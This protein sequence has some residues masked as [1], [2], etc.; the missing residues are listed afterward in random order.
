VKDLCNSSSLFF[1]MD[2]LIIQQ[3]IPPYVPMF[4]YVMDAQSNV[5]QTLFFLDS[6]PEPGSLSYMNSAYHEQY[7]R[8]LEDVHV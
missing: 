7:F 2:G 3:H 1:G 6:N 8:V 4:A 5:F